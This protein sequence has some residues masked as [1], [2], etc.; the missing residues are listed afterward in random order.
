MDKRPPQIA[1]AKAQRR[2]DG[3][4]QPRHPPELHLRVCFRESRGGIKG[5]TAGHSQESLIWT[6]SAAAE[7]R[8]GTVGS[9]GQ[10][11]SPLSQSQ[12]GA[13]AQGALM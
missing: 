8:S 9:Q 10:G 1:N 13:E 5:V 12:V 3:C 4:D 7:V 2:S 11:L 6:G